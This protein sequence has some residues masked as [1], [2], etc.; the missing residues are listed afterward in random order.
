ML[1]LWFYG[2]QVLTLNNIICITE[3]V[4][5]MTLQTRKFHTLQFKL[6]TVE[7]FSS[8]LSAIAQCV[9]YHCWLVLEIA[10][11]VIL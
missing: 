6:I 1:F 8:I 2:N 7:V 11:T 5:N 10:V 3:F 4:W 9:I